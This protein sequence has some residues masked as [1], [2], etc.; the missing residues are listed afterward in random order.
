MKNQI[1]KKN[2]SVKAN[3]TVNHVLDELKSIP[4]L[5]SQANLTLTPFHLALPVNNLETVYHFY[6]DQLGGKTGRQTDRWLDLSLFGHQMSFHLYS[7]YQAPVEYAQGVNGDEIPV[8]HFGVVLDSETWHAF[9]SRIIHQNMEFTLEPRIRF[10]GTLG[11]QGTFF[12]RDPQGYLLEFKY[13]NQFSSLFA[14]DLDQ[15]SYE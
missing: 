8:P 12:L 10:K 5:S 15:E 2:S 14:H 9:A 1:H 3:E 4:P 7:Q 13:F 6:I 11:E